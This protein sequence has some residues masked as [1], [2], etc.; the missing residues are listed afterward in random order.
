MR[1]EIEEIAKNLDFYIEIA[2]K[3]IG[4]QIKP[5]TY[6]QTPKIYKWK[7]WLSSTYEKF[8]KENGRK[9]IYD[10]EIIEDIKL[11]INGKKRIHQ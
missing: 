8:E 3:Y 5:I 2:G 11:V 9:E 7:E 10:K 1:A 4:I 6:E